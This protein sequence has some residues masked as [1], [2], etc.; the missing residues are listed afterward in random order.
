MHLRSEGSWH[1]DNISGPDA[2]NNISEQL[3]ANNNISSKPDAIDILASELM[4]LVM[5]KES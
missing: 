2:N 1:A 5:E 3:D 4:K